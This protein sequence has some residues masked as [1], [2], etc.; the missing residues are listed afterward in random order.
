[1]AASPNNT[2]IGGA[3]LWTMTTPSRTPAEYKA[4]AQFLQFIGQPEQD[5]CTTRTPATCR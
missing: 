4:V 2:I 3:S 1:M 5:A